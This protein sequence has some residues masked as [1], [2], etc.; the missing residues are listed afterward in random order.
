[1]PRRVLALACLAASLALAEEPAP[2]PAPPVTVQETALA[3]VVSASVEAKR[4]VAD[5]AEALAVHL[6]NAAALGA[7]PTSARPWPASPCTC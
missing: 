1:M 3:T 2:A 7:P 6:R 4:F 5:H